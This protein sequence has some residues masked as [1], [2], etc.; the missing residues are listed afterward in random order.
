MD[1][2]VLVMSFLTAGGNKT[3]VRLKGIKSDIDETAVSTA[4]D[5]L[6]EKNIFGTSTGD[7]KFKD[8]ASIVTTE[9]QELEI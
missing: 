5:T 9:E 4:M 2:R 3:S 7:L 8:S 6:I 1:N